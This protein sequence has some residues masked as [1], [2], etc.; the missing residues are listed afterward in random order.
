METAKYSDVGRVR[1]LNE[2]SYYISE[3]AQAYDTIYAMVADGM[4]GHK[5]GEVA[6][7]AAVAEVSAFIN[8][9]Y[10]S[11]LS[12]D[13][14]KRLLSA[15][16][17]SANDKVYQMSRADEAVSGMGT[18]LTLLL[19]AGVKVFIA[20]V[21]DSRAYVLADGVIHRMTRDHSMVEELLSS[22]QI[23]PAQARS[24]PQKNVITRAIGTEPT[25]EVDTLQTTAQPGDI[26]LLCTDGL[27]NL[28]S[29][30]EVAALISQSPSME[31]AASLLTQTA[32]ERG[33]PDNIT[34]VLLKV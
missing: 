10:T 8:K 4:G 14:V 30:S 13:N 22:G 15:A 21:G 18:T 20:H 6:S 29:D 34:V 31:A 7:T 17:K 33:G 26:F 27:T 16:L 1:P 5:A 11:E 12:D 32:N 9:H 2:D 23:T 25:I 24:H 3:Y 19:K 28:L